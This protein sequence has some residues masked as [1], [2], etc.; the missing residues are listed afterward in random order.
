MTLAATAEAGRWMLVAAAALVVAGAA[1]L[2]PRIVALRRRA[3]LVETHFVEA[4]T[5]LAAA[6]ER[7]EEDRVEMDELLRPWR[8]TWRWATHP[9]TWGMIRWANERVRG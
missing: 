1:S 8:L 2:V 9:L 6:W 7:I 3:R 4:R 5:R